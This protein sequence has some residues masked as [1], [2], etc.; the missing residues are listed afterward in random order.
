MKFI[1]PNVLVV[2]Y[3]RGNQYNGRPWKDQNNLPAVKDTLNII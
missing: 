2:L 3:L 1:I